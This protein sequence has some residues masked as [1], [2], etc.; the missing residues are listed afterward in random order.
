[1]GSDAETAALHAAAAPRRLR[2]RG[3]RHRRELGVRLIVLCQRR[4]WATSV[5][6]GLALVPIGGP[7]LFEGPREEDVVVAALPLLVLASSALLHVGRGAASTIDRFAPWLGANL[8]V[9]AAWSAWLATDLGSAPALIRA[10]AL[11]VLAVLFLWP[12]AAASIVPGSPPGD[13]VETSAVAYTATLFLLPLVGRAFDDSIW[14]VFF[15]LAVAVAP[16]AFHAAVRTRAADSTVLFVALALGLAWE[17]E[18]PP[19]DRSWMQR[20]YATHFL[21]ALSCLTC[22]LL[23][24]AARRCRQMTAVPRDHAVFMDFY[25]S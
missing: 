14:P 8:G 10:A 4:P 18:R 19:N 20:A 24:L 5:V 7:W 13:A 3:A 17:F 23:L 22:G 1:M 25:V 6:F 9:L 21:S 2:G 15:L 12:L 11:G 16:L